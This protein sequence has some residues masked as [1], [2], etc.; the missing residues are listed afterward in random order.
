MYPGD[1]DNSAG[2]IYIWPKPETAGLE[3]TPKYY[4]TMTTLDTYG[5]ETDVPI[6]SM[7]AD[8]ALSEIY[9]IRAQEDK[10]TYYD[11]LFR[12]QIDLLKL[13]LAAFLMFWN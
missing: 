6:P 5:D 13:M 2:Y 11:K 12:E 3:I 7:L 10:A 4:K 8:Y 9:K 1:S